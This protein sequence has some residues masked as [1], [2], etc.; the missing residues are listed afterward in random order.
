MTTIADL[1][2][3]GKRA[4][5]AA[6]ERVIDPDKSYTATLKTDKG[7]IVIELAA[8]EAPNTVN[9]FVYL[10][11]V[12]FYDGLSF[13]RVIANFMIQGGDPKGDGTGG[14]GYRFN[15]EFSP[16]GA[17]AAPACSPWPTPARH[18]RQPVLHHPRGPAAPGRP[19]LRL[20]QG[21]QRPGRG[22]RHPPGR[23]DPAHRYRREVA[24]R[25]RRVEPQRCAGKSIAQALAAVFGCPVRPH[26]N[27]LDSR[28][29]G[30]SASAGPHH[31]EGE[32]T[33]LRAGTWWNRSRVLKN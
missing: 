10:S 9:N 31:A 8:K 32:R 19:P 29:P 22:Q 7:D 23:Q 11:S 33:G 20:R 27:A 16:S 18:Q 12:G 4:F 15:D 25:P 28:I 3:T 17:T 30:G 2:R 6:P 26:I 24:A 5:T 21:D 1:E 14:P 13:H